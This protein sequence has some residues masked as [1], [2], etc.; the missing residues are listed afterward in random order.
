M[1][2]TR[3][4]LWF[5]SIITV[6]AVLIDLPQEYPLNISLGPINIQRV[7]KAPV[8]DIAWGNFSLEK[9]FQTHYG[10]D[11]SGGTHLALE[12]DMSQ[13]D[14]ESRDAAFASAR[15]II[16]RRVNLYGVTEPVIQESKV[17]DSYRI[18]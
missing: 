2:N 15:S 8:L 12:A 11:L 10:L 1:K 6:L 14:E 9:D 17:G 5:I 16:E 18:I 13:I 3:F 4:F 7:I